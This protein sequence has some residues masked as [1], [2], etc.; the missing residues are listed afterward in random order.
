MPRA[1]RHDLDL[2]GPRSGRS[3]AAS[4][5]RM[6]SRAAGA[7]ACQ[8]AR[9]G[10]QLAAG[11]GRRDRFGACAVAAWP[12]GRPGHNERVDPEAGPSSDIRMHQAG[13]RHEHRCA[14]QLRC[15]HALLARQPVHAAVLHAG[16]AAVSVPGSQRARLGADRRREHALH[17]V[18]I[19]SFRSRS[20]PRHGRSSRKGTMAAKAATPAATRSFSIP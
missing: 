9:P 15:Q 18:L 11:R 13:F 17:H 4:E 20:A 10:M 2:Y 5:R 6:E 3:S 12:P 7:G 14:A 16:P 19:P 8:S 1:Q